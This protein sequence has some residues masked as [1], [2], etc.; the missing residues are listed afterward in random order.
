MYNYLF[1]HRVLETNKSLDKDELKKVLSTHVIATNKVTT[2]KEL[3]L[4]KVA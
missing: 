3:R 4:L 2:I 1:W